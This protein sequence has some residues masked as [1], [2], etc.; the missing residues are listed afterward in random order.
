MDYTL[1]VPDSISFSQ[2]FPYR[3]EVSDFDISSTYDRSGIVIRNSL[4]QMRYSRYELWAL[5]PQDAIQNLLLK[6]LKEMGIFA[7]VKREYLDVRPDFTI[8]G[9]IS[10]IELYH[11]PGISRA[12]IEMELSLQDNQNEKVII[13][14][15]FTRFEKLES[16]N[17]AF[18]AKKISDIL[19]EENNKFILKI[20]NYFEELENVEQK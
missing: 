10:N 6:H 19:K 17:F 15:H 11:S 7:E 20:I 4:H 18:F 13:T 12:D 9:T 3:V 5:R 2:P 1:S 16:D 14:H 8:L